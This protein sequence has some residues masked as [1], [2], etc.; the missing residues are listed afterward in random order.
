MN[1]FRT[2]Q[3]FSDEYLDQCKSIKPEQIIKFLEEF[4]TLHLKSRP[5]NKA[6]SEP[7]SVTSIESP[8]RTPAL[9]KSEKSKLIS[10]KIPEDLLSEFKSKAQ[11]NGI[12]YQTQIKKLMR[13]W[14]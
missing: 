14:I 1:S 7:A 9:Q 11:L 10:I 6:L 12:A 8:A 5:I 2:I 4:Q 13:G 3:Y